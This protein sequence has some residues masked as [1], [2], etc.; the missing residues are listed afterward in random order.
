MMDKILEILK[1]IKPEIN[2]ETG[3]GLV[4]NHILD[5][6]DVTTLISELETEF[7]IEIGM[8]YMDQANFDSAEDIWKMV[9][10]VKDE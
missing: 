6:I 1:K 4:T 3:K 9:C 7:D 5:S 8:E 10:L 2:F